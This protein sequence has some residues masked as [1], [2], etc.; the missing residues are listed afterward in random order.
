MRHEHLIAE[1]KRLAPTLAQI[2]GR[3]PRHHEVLDAVAKTQGALG[4]SELVAAT[5]PSLRSRLAAL[6][7]LGGAQPRIGVPL[8]ALLYPETTEDLQLGVCEATGQFHFQDR[9]NQCRHMLAA[10]SA[11]SGGYTFVRDMMAQHMVRGGGLLFVERELSDSHFEDLAR[12]AE[13]LGRSND[14]REAWAASAVDLRAAMQERRV[15]RYRDEP[16]SVARW[17]MRDLHDALVANMS[18]GSKPN[19]RTPFMVVV[20]AGVLL[21]S[22]MTSAFMQQARGQGVAF[23]ATTQYGSPALEA[24]GEELLATTWTKVFFRSFDMS[25]AKAAARVVVQAGG[26]RNSAPTGAAVLDE[27]VVADALMALDIGEYLLVAPHMCLQGA[28]GGSPV[29][30]VRARYPSYFQELR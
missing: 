11:G 9:A 18:E 12:L 24:E 2:L 29:R 19:S 4:W 25:G 21:S 7:G 13:A 30:K 1:A 8:D 20:D 3:R 27:E 16:A 6:C 15:V 22:G 26:V 17:L 28:G 23:V 14:I 5:R 10:A